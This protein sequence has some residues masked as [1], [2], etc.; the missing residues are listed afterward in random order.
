M[1]V[2][3]VFWGPILQ[4]AALSNWPIRCLCVEV[5]WPAIIVT[6][7]QMRSIYRQNGTK[8]AVLVFF[9]LAAATLGPSLMIPP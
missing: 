8:T 6:V 7:A 5:S 2:V 9:A 3:F 4:F 1:L